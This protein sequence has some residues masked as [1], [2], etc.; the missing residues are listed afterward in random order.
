M[1]S[2]QKKLTTIPEMESE[3]KQYRQEICML[4]ENVQNKLILEEQVH[5]LNV[6]LSS[7]NNKLKDIA[8]IQVD[9]ARADSLLKEWQAVS[10]S[11]NRENCTPKDLKQY[12]EELQKNELV[13][14]ADKLKVQSNLKAVEIELTNVKQDMSKT[15]TQIT[16]LKNS[17][18]QHQNILHRVQKKLQQVAKERDCYR[19]LVDSYDQDLTIM[20]TNSMNNAEVL[21]KERIAAMEKIVEGYKEQVES[22]ERNCNQLFRKQHPPAFVDQLARMQEENSKLMKENDRLTK[23]CDECEQLLEK[24]HQNRSVTSTTNEKI[25][26]FTLNPATNSQKEYKEDVKQLQ[27]EIERLK[28]KIKNWKKELQILISFYCPANPSYDIDRI[29]PYLRT[30]DDHVNTYLRQYG[31]IP[32]FLSALTLDLVKRTTVMETTNTIQL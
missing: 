32:A 13:L 30:L 4:R 2:L 5:D 14:T 1:K 20:N 19:G 27:T 11:F 6:K 8:N 15:T 31:S 23:R 18:K 26:H 25:L 28:K 21:L 10:R 9:F 12:I 22:L 29:T 24:F 3:L 7:A 17:L 16:D